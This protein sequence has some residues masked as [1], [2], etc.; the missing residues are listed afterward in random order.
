MK[1]LIALG[2]ALSL[3]MAAAQADTLADTLTAA[4]DARLADDPAWADLLQYEPYP[5]TGHLRSLADDKGFFNAPDGARNPTA[6]LDATL[7]RLFEP[8]RPE[9]PDEHPQCRFPARHH[10]LRQRL[11]LS[12]MQLPEQPCPRLEKW[13]AEIN[14]AG[15]T[16]VFPSAYVNSP[17]SMFGH[18]LLRID[19]PEQTEATRLLA[20][21]INYA[22]KADAT[23]GFTFALKGL[24][25]LYPGALSSSPYYAKVREYSDMESRD[26]WEYRLNLT[27]AETRQLL[28]H[29]WEIGATRFDYWFFDENCSYMIL[30]LLDV[31][32]PGLRVAKQFY[33]TAI[34]V[35][36]VKGVVAMPDLVTDIRFR[37]STGTELAHRA[38]RLAPTSLDAAIAV[39]DGRR[40]P[41]SLGTDTQ[42][43]EQLEFADR[44]VS[45][46]GHAG[47]LDQ[48]E[49]LARLKAIQ[50]IRSQLPTI[51]TGAIP[52]PPRPENG[53]ASGRA[54]LATGRLDGTNAL[55][56]DLRPAYHDLLD[57][58]TGYARGAQIRFLD[59]GASQREGQ[60][61]RLDRFLPVDIV[62]VAPRLSWTQPLSW[63]VRFGWE[64]TLGARR[65]TGPMVAGGPGAAWEWKGL[66]GYVFLENQLLGHGDLQKHWAIGSGPLAGLLWD[67]GAGSRLQLEAG[68]QWFNDRRLDRSTARAHLRTRLTPR[69]NL[70]AGYEW[71]H[72]ELPDTD[73][74]ERR[75]TLGWQHYF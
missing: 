21:T 75:L 73:R 8:A 40:T 2:T 34:P 4:R 11:A 17:A 59:L 16:L 6:E 36:T 65:A 71:T 9:A 39:A 55:F 52:V 3:T 57:A 41:Q 22:A 35:D 64:R 53:H 44:L 72:I 1:I 29:A 68:R 13:A 63:K 26:V 70:V 27:P 12:P 32:R 10:W 56:L 61:W 31:A 50:I 37:P 15:V 42:A 33:W 43:I 24:T 47:K 46:R 23:D 7:A 19:T 69:D 74:A 67:V 48:D 45:L 66:L 14:P 54:G 30:R 62:S 60:G 58:E 49:A 25:G 38:S 20:Y 5:I 51:D 28:R 18:T